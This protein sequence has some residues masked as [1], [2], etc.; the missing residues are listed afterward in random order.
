MNSVGSFDL[1]IGLP[2]WAGAIVAMT[3]LAALDLVTALLAQ[4]SAHAGTPTARNV[5]FLVGVAAEVVLFTIYCRSLNVADLLPVTFG[6]IAILQIGLLIWG[7]VSDHAR[8]TP[9]QWL[10]GVIIIVLEGYL[11]ASSQP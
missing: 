10:A 6:W 9:L 11:L 5:Y 4:G 7:S 2:R 1:G 3:L 8:V